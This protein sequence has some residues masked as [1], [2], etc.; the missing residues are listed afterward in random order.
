MG[1]YKNNCQDVICYNSQAFIIEDEQSYKRQTIT[2]YCM[3]YKNVNK[4]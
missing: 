3:K 4:N 1:M 2:E